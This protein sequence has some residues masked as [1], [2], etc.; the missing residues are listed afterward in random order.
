MDDKSI[1]R[2]NELY[3]K[4]KAEGL[5]E[6]EA[7]EQKVLRRQYIDDFKRNLRGQLNN[8][9][10][11]KRMEALQIWEKNLETKKEIRETVLK[12]RRQYPADR[13]HV[14]STCIAEKVMAHPYF[15]QADTVY[16]YVDFDGE[17]ETRQIINEALARENSCMFKVHGDNMEFYPIKSLTELT[18]GI[19]GIPGAACF[20]DSGGSIY[21]SLR[22]LMILPGVA[23]D[24]SRNRIGYGRGYYDR[25]LKKH[26]GFWTMALAFEC[27]MVEKI[28]AED[29]DIRPQSLITETRILG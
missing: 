24:V 8:V 23:F 3:H 20:G 7:R 9:P 21:D 4:S 28:P 17:V 6:A 29:T 16:C 27:Q 14:F 1:A 26:G 10:F 15:M 22:T 19:F 25:Y 18:K 5:T 2:I 11:R 13:R 12:K